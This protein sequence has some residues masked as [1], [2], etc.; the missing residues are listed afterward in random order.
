MGPME[1]FLVVQ[2]LGLLVFTTNGPGSVPS[3][4]TEIPRATPPEKKDV[5][6]MT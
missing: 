6:S 3:W 4:G 1:N 5:E 2:W